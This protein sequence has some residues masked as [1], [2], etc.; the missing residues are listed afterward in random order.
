MKNLANKVVKKLIKKCKE[1]FDKITMG[2]NSQS[3]KFKRK[4]A[5]HCYYGESILN[6]EV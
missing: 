1:I 5:G 2:K 3:Q 4:W 6:L